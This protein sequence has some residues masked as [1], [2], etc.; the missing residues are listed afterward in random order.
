MWCLINITSDLWDSLHLSRKRRSPD[1]RQPELQTLLF[2]GRGLNPEDQR[3]SEVD[4]STSGH[5][6]TSMFH[7]GISKRGFKVGEV[8]HAWCMFVALCRVQCLYKSECLKE[9]DVCFEHN[10]SLAICSMGFGAYIS[11][12][13]ID[14]TLHT[15]LGCG[16]FTIFFRN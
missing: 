15:K 4:K 16:S 1:S 13:L 11:R 7:G 8:L 9:T 6:P 2:S 3:G 10:N 14:K 5:V 12:Q